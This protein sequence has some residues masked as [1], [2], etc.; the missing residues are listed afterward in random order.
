MCCQAKF[1]KKEV[2]ERSKCVDFGYVIILKKSLREAFYIV[3]FRYE[4]PDCMKRGNLAS[5][6]RSFSEYHLYRS[7]KQYY[8]EKFF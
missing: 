3:C 4:I 1:S 2:H 6:L 5:S 8:A 7:D